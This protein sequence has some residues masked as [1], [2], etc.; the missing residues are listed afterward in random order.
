M[1]LLL[2]SI[3]FSG[4]TFELPGG[5]PKGASDKGKKNYTGCMCKILYGALLCS[6]GSTYAVFGTVFSISRSGE[7]QGRGEDENS[8]SESRVV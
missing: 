7:F 3:I 5:E 8:M 6:D 2:T 4:L 1:G